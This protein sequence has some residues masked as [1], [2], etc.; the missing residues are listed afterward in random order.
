M[1]M[2]IRK[3]YDITEASGSRLFQAISVPLDRKRQR[4]ERGIMLRSR[5]KLIGVAVAVAFIA[6]GCSS[7]KKASSRADHYQQW[8][9]NKRHAHYGAEWCRIGQ[10]T[11]QRQG[12]AGRQE[13]SA[14]RH[15]GAAA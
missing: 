6:M 4:G 14:D 9:N 2:I 12:L 11:G 3:I 1:S 8:L 10:D 13:R 5:H 7:S 15:A